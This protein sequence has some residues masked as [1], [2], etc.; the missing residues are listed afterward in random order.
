MPTGKDRY[1][2]G[3][4]AELLEI[5]RHRQSSD[6]EDHDL[7]W[8]QDVVLWSAINHVTAYRADFS[9]GRATIIL[10][11]LD[12]REIIKTSMLSWEQIQDI[13]THWCQLNTNRR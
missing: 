11:G 6:A 8:Q 4:T 9:C 5:V 2:I 12:G 10:H 7:V 1:E 13:Y 3:L